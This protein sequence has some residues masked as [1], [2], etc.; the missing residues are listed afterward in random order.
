MNRGIKPEIDLSQIAIFTPVI[1]QELFAQLWGRETRSIRSRATRGYLPLYR[2]GKYSLINI[3]Q[4]TRD[5]LLHSHYDQVTF[6]SQ[7]YLDLPLMPQEVFANRVGV[8]DGVVRGWVNKGYLPSVPSGKE[9]L[10]NVVELIT[11]CT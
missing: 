3:V 2:I 9:R 1:S 11:R 6:I 8:T 5:S 4:L 7:F 10:V